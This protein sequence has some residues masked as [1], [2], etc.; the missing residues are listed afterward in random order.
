V[1]QQNGD[2]A[3]LLQA[4]GWWHRVTNA[5][6]LTDGAA[7]LN[8]ERR[9]DEEQMLEHCIAQAAELDLASGT[10]PSAGTSSVAALS[11]LALALHELE[12]PSS[13]SSGHYYW[14]QE[15]DSLVQ[16]VW[17]HLAAARRSD[18][19]AG[20]VHLLGSSHAVQAVAW[21]VLGS[22]PLAALHADLGVQVYADKGKMPCDEAVLIRC[23]AALQ[24]SYPQALQMLL[25][26]RSKVD[27]SSVGMWSRVVAHIL[28]ERALLR[29][30]LRRAQAFQVQ[31]SALSPPRGSDYMPHVVARH[32]EIQLLLRL[33]QHEEAMYK[34]QCFLEDCEARLLPLEGMKCLQAVAEACQACNNST[35]ALMFASRSRSLAEAHQADTHAAAATVIIAASLLQLGL[36]AQASYALESKMPVILREAPLLVCGNA[37]LVLAK[38]H[39]N[40]GRREGCEAAIEELEAAKA[41]FCELHA[42]VELEEALYLQAQMYNTLGLTAQRN[43]VAQSFA[44]VQREAA[45]CRREEETW[46]PDYGDCAR[47]LELELRRVQEKD[48]L[49]QKQ[50]LG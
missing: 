2:H 9:P 25:D 5:L 15:S 27:P 24:R 37:H 12:Q 6:Q 29:G 13:S 48:L 4:L 23:Q 47:A 1:A 46:G 22:G 50:I 16:K 33:G 21:S 11:H 17:A 28:Q 3:C 35:A 40:E 43:Q 41:C 26:A 45:A 19:E 38:C 44:F 14:N 8:A 34:A 10:G 7:K 42:F 49:Y 36:G 18:V 31:L 32:A 30:E 39:I 20:Q